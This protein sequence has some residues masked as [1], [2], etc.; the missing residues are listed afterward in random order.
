MSAPQT[1]TIAALDKRARRLTIDLGDDFAD[2]RMG[3]ARIVDD[4]LDVLEGK[5]RSVV[6]I[7]RFAIMRPM[8]PNDSRFHVESD[9][10]RA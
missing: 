6:E 3:I 1:R 8:P 5:R 7:E 2:E 10:G 9:E 4:A